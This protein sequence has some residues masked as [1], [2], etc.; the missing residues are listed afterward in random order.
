M[1]RVALVDDHPLMLKIVR[2]ELARETDL[3]I[4][5]ESIDSGAVMA[6]AAADT[7]DVLVLDLSFAGQAFEPAAAVRDLVARF[8]QMMILILTAYV[9]LLG[10]FVLFPYLIFLG[11]GAVVLAVF[12]RKETAEEDRKKED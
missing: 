7:P 1:I 6:R 2:Q 3:A 12:P 9:P 11:V 5:W 10:W 8:P 4:I